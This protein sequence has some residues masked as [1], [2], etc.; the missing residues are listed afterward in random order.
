MTRDPWRYRCPKDHAS[1]IAR[2]GRY[3]CEVCDEYYQELV[4]KKE[5][6]KYHITDPDVTAV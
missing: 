3:Y 1:W 6:A 2:G 5:P 4:D